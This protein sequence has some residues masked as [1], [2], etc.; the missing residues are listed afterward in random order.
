MPLYY[1]ARDN[2]P[3]DTNGNGIANVW[4]ATTP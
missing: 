3:G 2:A 1:F 4:F